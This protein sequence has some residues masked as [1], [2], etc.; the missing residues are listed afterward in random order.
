VSAVPLPDPGQS[1]LSDELRARVL[2]AY[3]PIARYVHRAAL[4]RAG[5]GG[6]PRLVD[7]SSWLRID[8]ACGFTEPCYI[9]PTGHFNAVEANITFNQLLYLALAECVRLQLIPELRHWQLDDFF[10]AQLPDVLIADY[11]AHFRRPM[12]CAEYDGWLT[13]ADVRGKA[14]RRLLLL[15]TRAG[16]HDRFGGECAVEATIAIVNWQPA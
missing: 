12:Q 10:R 8:G 9:E 5:N 13:F 3:R 11:G 4:T 7:P 1:L 15:Q 16:F 2:A 14:Q 6:S